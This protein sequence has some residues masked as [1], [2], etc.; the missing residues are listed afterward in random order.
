MN[1]T[2]PS[3][4]WSNT[5]RSTVSSGALSARSHSV[6][7]SLRGDG[8]IEVIVACTPSSLSARCTHVVEVPDPI[9]T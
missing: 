4:S 8:S 2:S 7:T 6:S 5:D 1:T 9:S 3:P